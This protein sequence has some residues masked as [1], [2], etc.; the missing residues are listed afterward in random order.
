MKQ[1]KD[2][3]EPDNLEA[4]KV[5]EGRTGGRG[6][7]REGAGGWGMGRGG[8]G[9]WTMGRGWSWWARVAIGDAT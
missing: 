8:A 1:S 6:M 5:R 9:G 4:S 7:G 2:A 3:R